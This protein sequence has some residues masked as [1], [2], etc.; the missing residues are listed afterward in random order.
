MNRAGALV[1]DD[2]KGERMVL[3]SADRATFQEH[4][5]RYALACG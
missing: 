2:N 4:L 5:Y 1:P 3:E